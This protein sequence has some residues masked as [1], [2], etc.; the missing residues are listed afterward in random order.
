MTVDNSS[1]L[2]TSQFGVQD[3]YPYATSF[4]RGQVEGAAQSHLVPQEHNTTTQ[5]PSRR[6]VSEQRI[7]EKRRK[8]KERHHKYRV[9]GKQAYSRICELL[10]IDLMPENTRAQRSECLRIILVWSIE[11]FTV[12]EA[13]EDLVEQREDVNDLRRQLQRAEEYTDILTRSSIKDLT[14]VDIGSSFPLIKAHPIHNRAYRTVFMTETYIG[15]T[16]QRTVQIA[17]WYFAR[18]RANSASNSARRASR[19]L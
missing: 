9:D 8:D 10:E 19:S 5:E 16:D 4:L 14:G 6:R 7:Q 3:D 11:H 18:T 12:L 15:S 17:H 1:S 13:V 2:L